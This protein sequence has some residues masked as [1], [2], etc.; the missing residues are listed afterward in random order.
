IFLWFLTGA[1]EQYYDSDAPF[2]V[3]LVGF[4]GIFWWTGYYGVYR[5][6]L[7]EERTEIRALRQERPLQPE[8]ET[9]G[10]G[11]ERELRQLMVEEEL[12]RDPD[13]GRQTVA[14][15]LGISEGY[16]S[17]QMRTGLGQGFVDFVNGYRVQAARAMLTDATFL[18]YSLE[19][20]GREAGFKSRSAFYSSFKKATGKTPGAYRKHPE[21]S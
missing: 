20:I 12:Y 19:A 16:L 18:P 11:Y 5:Q 14:E 21:M 10:K 2:A 4:S 6:R 7:A 1:M 15:R 13:L 3:L 9:T 8:P 17:E